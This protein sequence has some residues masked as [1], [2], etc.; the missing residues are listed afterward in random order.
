[1][2]ILSRL[3]KLEL[4]NPNKPQCFCGK[5]FIDLCYGKPGASALTFCPNCK[6]KFDFWAN[7]TAEAN[8]S[9]NLTDQKTQKQS[10]HI[11]PIKEN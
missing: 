2:N 1:M 7:L 3:K 8:L 10:E 4:K 11:E 5:T 6:D 9:E